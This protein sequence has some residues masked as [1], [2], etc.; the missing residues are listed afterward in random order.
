MLPQSG[1][2]H[3]ILGMV[4]RLKNSKLHSMHSA[5]HRARAREKS[6]V[7]KLLALDFACVQPFY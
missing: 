2:A 4:K 6:K 3:L 7:L 5:L 1:A